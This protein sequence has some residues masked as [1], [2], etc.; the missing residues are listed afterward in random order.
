MFECVR[1][2]REYKLDGEIK[3]LQTLVDLMT[4]DVLDAADFF[5]AGG[6]GKACKFLREVALVLMQ[7]YVAEMDRKTKVLN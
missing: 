2:Q 4:S 3:Q 6:E 5:N 7:Y 1:K